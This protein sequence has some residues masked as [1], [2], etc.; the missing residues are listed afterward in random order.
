MMLPMALLAGAT[1]IPI[2]AAEVD[3]YR[4]LAL[5][6]R[7]GWGIEF[8]KPYLTRTIRALITEYCS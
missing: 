5:M 4:L 6:V 7:R 2:S 8:E 1:C 3:R